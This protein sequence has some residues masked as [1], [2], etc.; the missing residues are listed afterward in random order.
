M[1]RTRAV[2]IFTVDLRLFVRTSSFFQ[3]GQLAA[4]LTGVCVA[5]SAVGS[6]FYYGERCF[7]FLRTNCSDKTFSFYWVSRD[8]T[9]HCTL[10]TGQVEKFLYDQIRHGRNRPISFE[11]S[12]PAINVSAIDS[13]KKGV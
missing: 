11:A 2:D 6:I 4:C 12:R 9:L 10:R 5:V 13:T 1:F 7:G 3:V 8:F